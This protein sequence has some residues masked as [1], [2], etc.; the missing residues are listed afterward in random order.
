MD[1]RGGK[2]HDGILASSQ[3]L[4]QQYEPFLYRLLELTGRRRLKLWCVGH[5]LGAGTAALASLEFNAAASNNGTIDAHALGFGTPAI[6]SKELS[7]ALK[8]TVTTVINDADCV[9]RMSGATLVNAWVSAA[10]YREWVDE[11]Q[12]DIRLLMSAM[13][14]NLPFPDLTDKILGGLLV[15]VEKIKESQQPTGPNDDTKNVHVT[16]I[17][18]PPGDCI[19]LYRDSTQWQGVYMP[20]TSFGEI[21]AV[22]HTVWDHL[23]PNGYYVG[24]LQYLRVLTKDWNWRFD[25]DLMKL[26]VPTN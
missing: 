7:L 1:Y 3:W 17:L 11:A 22:A 6:V 12:L 18:F 21:E 2:A 19:H 23:I 8:S 14:Q 26:P 15:W 5:S 25:P 4:H 13:K 10:S 16:P 9:P 20:C 24:L